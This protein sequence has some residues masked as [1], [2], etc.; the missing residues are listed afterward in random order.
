MKP[1]IFKVGES[2]GRKNASRFLPSLRTT[3]YELRTNAGFSV[4]EMLITAAIIGIIT[5]LVTIKYGSFNNLILLKNQAYQI[6]L[7]MRE[8]QTQSISAV[9][10]GED[11]RRPYGLYF[12]TSEPS[13]YRLFI[14]MD[15]PGDSG[16]G[17]YNAGEELEVRNLDSRF[18][19]SR[20]CSG[21]NCSLTTLSVTFQRPNFDAIINGG[22]VSDASIEI[23]AVTN[24]SS[25]RTVGVNAAGQITVQ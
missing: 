13:R 14:D 18:R 16:Y 11:F 22:T 7:E 17:N 9:G 8:M 23:T 6:A 15:D 20:L 21:S 12:T 24:S 5:A 4:L 25:T 2:K 19:L 1:S 3:N 10:R